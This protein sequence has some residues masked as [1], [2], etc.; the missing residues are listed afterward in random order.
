MD[1]VPAA[2]GVLWRV[3]RG[4][5]EVAVVHRPRYDD[6]SL[7]KGKSKKGESLL[8]TAL[9]EVEEETG[10]LPLLGPFLG[11]HVYPLSGGALKEVSSWSLRVRGGEFT[12]NDEVDDLLWLPLV[13]AERRLSYDKDRALLRRLA[14]TPR[15]T[16]TVA[17]VRNAHRTGAGNGPTRPETGRPG[18]VRSGSAPRAATDPLDALGRR[19][20][21]ALVPVLAALVPSTLVCASSPRS[22][23][24][25]RPAAEAL[26]L[27]LR[28]DPRLG[29]D[30]EPAAP[31]ALHELARELLEAPGGPSVAVCLHGRSVAALLAALT[32]PAGP[33]G[34]AAPTGQPSVPDA[35][36]DTSRDTRLGTGGC[37]LLHLAGT[38][39]V[40]S[41]RYHPHTSSARQR[42][43]LRRR[44]GASG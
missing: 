33:T 41:E 25:L 37:W 10:Y 24:S 11:R 14:G 43:A 27:P 7:P 35:G 13:A 42:R 12:P 6:W 17:V 29:R 5:P 20:V 39:L 36:E 2:G 15:W 18:S 32:G 44:E 19:Q 26:S 4:E 28:A 34:P 1:T 38:R 31:E 16:R 30:G 23:N 9:R 40:A 22:W 8:L 3:T 21:A